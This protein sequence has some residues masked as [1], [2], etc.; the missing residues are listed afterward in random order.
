MLAILINELQSIG[1]LSTHIPKLKTSVNVLEIVRRKNAK[2]SL[3]LTLQ[4]GF[5]NMPLNKSTLDKLPL[6]YGEED[7]L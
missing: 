4:G 2:L 6:I 1:N 5:Y 3:A 7:E